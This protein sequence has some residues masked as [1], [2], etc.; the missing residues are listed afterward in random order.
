V[1]HELEIH[2]LYPRPHQHVDP[3]LGPAHDD[4]LPARRRQRAKSGAPVSDLDASGARP[5]VSD[6]I[7][8]IGRA[9]RTAGR[10][11]GDDQ[12]K[13]AGHA[14]RIARAPFDAPV[15]RVYTPAPVKPPGPGPRVRF[16]PR[17]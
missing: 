2:V 3:T 16:P 4:E 6:R 14:D 13:E 1:E 7:A 5:A 10:E 8:A 11:E 15:R 12:G 9:W 17:M